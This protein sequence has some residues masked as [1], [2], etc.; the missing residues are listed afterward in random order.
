MWSAQSPDSCT[1]FFIVRTAQP[2]KS[3]TDFVIN[4]PA[5]FA[6]KRFPSTKILAHFSVLLSARGNPWL[7]SGSSQSRSKSV[8]AEGHIVML[9]IQF[10]YCGFIGFG[11]RGGRGQIR[12]EDCGP[13]FLFATA[14][15]YSD[16]AEFL[17]RSLDPASTWQEKAS[18][19]MLASM[20]PT[21]SGEAHEVL[22]VEDMCRRYRASGSK[23]DAS[24]I[25]SCLE[26][27]PLS[28]A[29]KMMP[30]D[31]DHVI[32]SQFLE[33]WT[34]SNHSRL[35]ETHNRTIKEEI[36]GLVTNLQLP[37][38][39]VRTMLEV[40]TYFLFDFFCRHVLPD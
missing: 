33:L 34:A 8:S 16:L 38:E 21:L 31:L 32:R 10:T 36:A 5:K 27:I 4:I 39:Y 29:E 23:E 6:T 24:L 19:A 3:A 15:G 9:A 26:G 22:D 28:S 35:R 14:I 12:W 40:F 30:P 17:V 13:L 37:M 25:V 18:A 20:H 11:D 7:V 2:S 1:E